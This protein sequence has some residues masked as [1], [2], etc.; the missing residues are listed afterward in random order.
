MSAALPPEPAAPPPE[1]TS[2]GDRLFLGLT[3]LSGAFVLALAAALVGVLT[4]QALP[5]L[6]KMEEYQLLTSADWKPASDADP[7]TDEEGEP[8]PP[9]KV[10]Y[11][12]LGFIFG[13]VATSLIAMLIAV[14]LGVGAAAYLSEVAS[15]RVRWVCSFLLELLAAIPSVVF[16][17]W[18]LEFL[19]H[20]TLAP[21]FD[22]LNFDN[23]SGEGILAAGLVLAVMILP[24]IT[25][26]SFDVCQAV[27]RSQREGALALGATRWHT[28]WTVVLPYAR[29]GIIAACFLALGRA[30]GE[31]M[32]VT[33]VIGNS[34]H[35]QVTP[36]AQGNTIPS[37]I[38]NQLSEATADK[39]PVLIALG[40]ILLGITLA[41]TVSARLLLT[42]AARP[43]ARRGRSVAV[44][45]TVRPPAAPPEQ[46][47]RARRRAALADRVMTAVLRGCQ[48]LT[49]IPLFMI[50]GYITY[51]GAGQVRW[52]FF[53]NLPN[54]DPPGLKH[55]LLGS[56]TLVGLASAFAIPVGLLA[57]VFLS[58]YRHHP[59]ARPVRFVA[60]Q[61]GGVPS[62]IVGVFAYAI[63]VYP[64]WLKLGDKSWGFSAWAGAFALAVMM[65]PI[66]IRAAEEAMRLVPNSLREASFA[67]GASRS[68]TVM[69]VIIPAALPAIVTGI[70]LA[71][72]RV[73]GETAPLLLTARGSQL[74]AESL[75]EPTPS[76]P[77]YVFYFSTQPEQ[78]FKDLVWAGAFV[79]VVLVLCLNVGTRLLAGKRVVA[80]A[81]S[82]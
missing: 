25:A 45:G 15:P 81:R 13:T 70:L 53:T 10:A 46:A 21:V 22:W 76:L 73:A 2:L 1:R 52:T 57:A 32:A 47:A 26:L 59:L 77:F 4:Y 44:D 79:L 50:L 56:A 36:D 33:M 34:D 65:L 66:V 35:L 9:P 49:V 40:L 74:V 51:R 54:D 14:P 42:W 61:L 5:A 82:D 69:R 80:A 67:L 23:H 30:A 68:Q 63:L 18:A 19:A 28:I 24:F 12:A 16:G 55:A 64:F 78:R 6:K 11:G 41:M 8:L 71:V 75:S 48:L 17:F 37:V 72:G 20:R 39:R 3:Q 7:G 29:P 62:I 31:T 27:P 60:E 58:E 38:A 43:R